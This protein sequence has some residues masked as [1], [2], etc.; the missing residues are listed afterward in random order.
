MAWWTKPKRKTGGKSTKKRRPVSRQKALVRNMDQ[1][2]SMYVRI[3]DNWTCVSCGKRQIPTK[4]KNPTGILKYVFNGHYP[5]NKVLT[6]SHYWG[7]SNKGLRWDL[8]LLDSLCLVCHQLIENNKTR[9]VRGF[10][11]EQY[12]RVKLGDD[13]YDMIDRFDDMKKSVKYSL[14][15]LEALHRDLFNQLRELAKDKE[16]L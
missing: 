5:V 11:Y 14:F 3:R 12:M 16:L 13:T 15:E 2:A 4:C 6:C 9:D 8:R 1:M 10:N 7:R